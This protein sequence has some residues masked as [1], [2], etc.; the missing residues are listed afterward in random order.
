MKVP[1]SGNLG[2]PCS[3]LY[4]DFVALQRMCD[5]LA[6]QNAVLT[7]ENAMMRFGHPMMASFQMASITAQSLSQ[8]EGSSMPKRHRKKKATSDPLVDDASTA[9]T[10]GNEQKAEDDSST[11]SRKSSFE[12]PEGEPPTTVMM[13]NLPN[14]MTRSTLLALIDAQGFEGCYDF[15]YLPTDFRS[16]AGLGYSFVNFEV[17]ET[18]LRFRD[19]FS[20]FRDWSFQSEKVCTTMWSSTQGRDAHIERYRNSPVMHESLLDEAKPLLFK[21]GN[22]VPFPAPTKRLRPPHISNRA[23]KR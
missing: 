22:R 9:A 21:D 16:Q 15:F 14:N 19:H 1:I 5:E 13:R 4:S 3:S 20:G 2:E 10:S 6:Y 11:P 8:L 17:S 18:A 12:T 23:G 7:N